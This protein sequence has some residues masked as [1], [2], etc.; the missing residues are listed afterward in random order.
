MGCL[1]PTSGFTSSGNAG[2]SRDCGILKDEM[3]GGLLNG[4]EKE[5]WVAVLDLPDN[6]GLVQRLHRRAQMH[7]RL[8]DSM[9]PHLLHP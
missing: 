2:R 4:S 1:A 7:S 6:T 3:P 5:K 9:P 8:L